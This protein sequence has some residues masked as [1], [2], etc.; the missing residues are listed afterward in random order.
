M[1]KIYLS[2]KQGKDSEFWDKNWQDA[3]IEE[4]KRFSQ[5]SF[6]RPIFD[7][8]FPKAG[9][10]LEAGCGLGHYLIYY[11]NRG[12]DIEGVDWAKETVKRILEYDNT[13]P[14]KTADVSALPYKDKY[15]K[16]YFS[17]GVIE[18][19]EQGPFKV[20]KE[21]YRV[22][23]TDG[24]L[25]ITVPYINLLR[26]VEDLLFF[27]LI[28]CKTHQRL[29]IDGHKMRYTLVK[30]HNRQNNPFQEFH[31]H[32]YAYK[33]KEIGSILRQAGFEI[34]Y[35]RGISLMWGLKD[36]ALVRMSYGKFAGSQS[37]PEAAFIDARPANSDNKIRNFLKRII[38]T[39]DY[40]FRPARPLLYCL[41][42]LCAN[43][44][45]FICKKR[46]CF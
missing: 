33:R 43:S 15:F 35:S 9:K 4:A 30:E 34:I 41:Q 45:L 22:L 12:Y 27:R 39:E 29:S 31:F 5:I 32:E 46:R 20:L 24:L 13:I 18:H 6:L 37:K 25:I 3:S 23:D 17:G 16:V 21:A 1:R 42:R 36:F 40:N 44:I 2:D 10:I 19:F 8:Y 28:N 7:K 11:R 38:I 14:I 26:A